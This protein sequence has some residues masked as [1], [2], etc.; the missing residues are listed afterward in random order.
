MHAA[1]FSVKQIHIAAVRRPTPLAREG[2]LTPAR[3][4]M[5]RTIALFDAAGIPQWKLVRLLGVSGAVV[6]RMLK[7]LTTLGLV[8]REKWQRDRRLK[9]VYLTEE[10]ERRLHAVLEE[11]E[12]GCRLTNIAMD[13][14]RS[15]GT[16]IWQD[17]YPRLVRARIFLKARAPFFHP[18][19]VAPMFDDELNDVEL[20]PDD[21]DDEVHGEYEAYERAVARREARERARQL[22]EAT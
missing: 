11:H 4:D 18:W 21:V 14:F 2:Q 12:W 3:F 15:W 17:I 22:L 20:K 5:L 1:F 9:I 19:R 6:S 7:Q 10:G 8:R 16:L 13:V